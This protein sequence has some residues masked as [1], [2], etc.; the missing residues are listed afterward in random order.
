V[1]S[2]YA[3]NLG[4]GVLH[5]ETCR[6]VKESFHHVAAYRLEED[7]FP[8][9]RKTIRCCGHCL[10]SDAQVHALVDAYNKGRKEHKL[11]QPMMIR[12]NKE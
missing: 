6:Y 7:I 5:R 1:I 11:S 3:L 9:Y 10:K 8:F 12:R 2:K 4:S